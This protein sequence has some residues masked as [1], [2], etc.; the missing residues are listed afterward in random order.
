M[1]ISR[2][3]V[4]AVLS[5][6]SWSGMT[7]TSAAEGT[8]LL[9]AGAAQMGTAGAGVASPQDANWLALNPAGLVHVTSD[10]VMSCE[11]I[12]G[13][14]TETPQGALGNT[15]AGTMK[16]SVVVFA[17]SV[18]WV[19]ASDGQALA[20]G[21]YTVSGLA[22]ELPAARSA[23]GAAGGY[24]RRAE[25]RFVTTSAAYARTVAKGLSLGMALNFDYVD[26]RSDSMTLSG[27]ETAGA[28]TMDR[29]LGAG[30]SLS[31][32][33]RWE[34]WSVAATY[35]SRQW[36][37]GFS[38]YADLFAGT[39]DQPQVVQLGVAWRPLPWLEPLLDYRFIDWDSLA[40]YNDGTAKSLGWR[41]QHIIKLACN[42]HIQPDLVL[43]AGVSYGRSPITESVAFTNGLTN[44]V[45]EL[46]ATVGVG[47]KPSPAWDVQFAYLHAFKKEVT[48]NGTDA[49]GLA[50]GTSIGL[51][52]DSL[53]LGAGWLY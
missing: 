51:E 50:R 29:S 13:R 3:S 44:L 21:F 11:I 45:S 39:P 26:F 53:T 41:D 52:V 38:R 23:P 1:K 36:M 31:L 4:L 40:L 16:D 20:L 32:L 25:E 27:A 47:W 12:N 7:T 46:H 9:G 6:V 22:L 34:Q 43:R 37:Q 35:T 5:C 2:T 15:A 42:A 48:D 18:A 17:P 8:R 28:F 33:K 24:D 30:F 14:S 49:F 19:R 10:A